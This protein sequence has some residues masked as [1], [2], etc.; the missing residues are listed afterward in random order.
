MT[1]SSAYHHGHHDSSDHT[2]HEDHHKG[3]HYGEG[4]DDCEKRKDQV[5]RITKLSG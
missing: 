2:N 3:D 1:V 5:A 4:D